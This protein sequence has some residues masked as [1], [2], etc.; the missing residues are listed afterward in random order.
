M[1]KAFFFITAVLLA[2]A[3][4]GGPAVASSIRDIIEMPR[5]SSASLSPDG[6]WVAYRE[7][8]P[9]ID[10]NSHEFSWWVAPSDGSVPPRRLGD[11]GVGAW[12]NGTIGGEPAVWAPDSRSIYYRVARGGEAQIWQ[13]R[14]DG[15]STR[16]VTTEPGNVAR[17]Q[18]A[19]NGAALL[20]SVGPVRDTIAGA[21]Q[22]AYDE[23][24]LIDATVDPS[25]PL[26][27][28]SWIDGAWASERLEG[29]WFGHSGM[30]G[31]APHGL[32]RLD[33]ATGMIREAPLALTGPAEGLKPF[34]VFEKLGDRLV[35]TRAP[36]GDQRGVA[37]ILMQEGGAYQIVVRSTRGE[38]Y[39]SDPVCTQGRMAGLAWEGDRNVLLFT[40]WNKAARRTSLYRWTVGS[41]SVERV[42]EVDGSMGS[43]RGDGCSIGQALAICVV[44]ATDTPP[45]IVAIDLSTRTLRTLVR[46]PDPLDPAEPR[47]APLEWRDSTGRVF[48]GLLAMPVGA[49]GPVPLFITYYNCD[50]FLRGGTGDDFPL[51]QMAARGIAALCINGYMLP[52]H[53]S[54]GV[55][56]YRIAMDSVG[57]VIDLLAGRGLIDRA[58]VGMG[59]VSFGGEVAVWIA[60]H[61]TMLR[62]VS[63]ANVLLSP[64]YYWFNAVQ[65]RDVPSMLRQYW[66][67]GDPDADRRTWSEV[68][69]AY[70]A[71]RFH[72]AL[73]MQVPEQEYR[74]NVEILARMQRA[75]VPVELWGFPGE[76]HIKWQPRHQLA[77]NTR[78]L[79]WFLF[80]L[81]SEVDPDPAKAS[82]YAR[83][84]S[85]RSSSQERAQASASIIGRRR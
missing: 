8:R 18:A 16:A 4:I 78:N 53:K 40:R 75:G 71:R 61:S 70:L 79:D 10:R 14:I 84:R 54:V 85:Y 51:R 12:L 50:G 38:M 37:Y 80:W 2:L 33:L 48:T 31:S 55:R 45:S 69:L 43:G 15:S 82:H 58:R 36:S 72:G 62:A 11:A 60:S 21:E 30:L 34:E 57:K 47:F 32:R 7:Q 29:A 76:A 19:E 13:A 9:S 59:G 20:Y 25:R 23:G 17:I 74:P 63:A 67:V 77:A 35:D 41:E 44:E 26:V 22:T 64:T 66:L 52:G 83:W 65:G 73:L 39:C 3:M 56:N 46:T 5:L 1:R 49:K 6:H 24:V 42:V 27:G 81:K 68:S 28:G